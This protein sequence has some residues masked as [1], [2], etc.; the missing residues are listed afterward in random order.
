MAGTATV[1]AA[2]VECH[3]NHRAMTQKNFRG[4]QAGLPRAIFAELPMLQGI[5]T[6]PNGIAGTSALHLICYLRCQRMA[7]WGRDKGH[8]WPQ[9]L[10]LVYMA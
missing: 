4:A 6:L 5:G 8:G 2:R 3:N 9:S 10:I 1:L 7:G